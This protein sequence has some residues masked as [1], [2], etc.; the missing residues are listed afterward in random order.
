MAKLIYM[1]LT[2]LDG[3]TEDSGGSFDWAV[4][5]AEVHAYVNDLEVD[6]GTDLYGRRMYET[7]AVWQTIGD[8]PD[9][10]QV[11]LDFAEVWNAMDKVV[12]SRTLDEVWTPRT[13]LERDFD[14]DGVDHLKRTAKHDLSIRGPTLAR[15]AFAAGLVDEIHLLVFPVAVGSGTLRSAVSVNPAGAVPTV[16]GPTQCSSASSVLSMPHSTTRSSV[17]GH[18]PSMIWSCWSASAVSGPVSMESCPSLVSA[19][20]TLP[21]R[22]LQGTNTEAVDRDQGCSGE[23]CPQNE[24][25]CADPLQPGCPR[26]CPGCGHVAERLPH[27]S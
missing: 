27:E 2:S 22:G 13:R 3:Y 23:C 20:A 24:Q 10:S 18:S 26:Q 25:T 6:V 11:E 7:M 1:A 14:P 21:A 4:P 19:K 15:H 9:V 12:Y 16:T 17:S 8:N 5:D